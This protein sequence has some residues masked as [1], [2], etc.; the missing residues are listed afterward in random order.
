MNRSQR[1]IS[2]CSAGLSVLLVFSAVLLGSAMPPKI[3]EVKEFSLIGIQA[4]TNNAKE[5]TSDGVIPRQWNKFF[6]EGILAR[7]PNKVDPT[8]Y[9]VYSDYASDRNG[10]YT[11]FI[12]AKVIDTSAVPAG[13]VANKVPAGRFAVVTS[14]KGPLQNVVPQAWQQI[15]T[16]EEKAQLGGSRSY[17]AD[18]EIYD[19]RSRDPQDSQVDIYV[20]IK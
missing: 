20:G 17:K 3:L 7:I 2:L 9:A 16:L 11:F 13:M 1:N 18:F 12:G 15:W 4:R 5:M 19:Q 10:D 14:A 8:I 6:T